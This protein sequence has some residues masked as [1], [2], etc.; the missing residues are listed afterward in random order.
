MVLGTSFKR[1][2]GGSG[3]AW[4]SLNHYIYKISIPAFER[5]DGNAHLEANLVGKMVEKG[6]GKSLENRL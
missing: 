4:R 3:V 2:K 5:F 6:G 1:K